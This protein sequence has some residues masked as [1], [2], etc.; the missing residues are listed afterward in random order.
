MEDMCLGYLS[1]DRHLTE[2]VRS[3][4]AIHRADVVV[5]GG[6]ETALRGGTVVAALGAAKHVD[7][8]G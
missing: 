5:L 1:R 6:S 4:A 2:W 8:M 3:M 7:M